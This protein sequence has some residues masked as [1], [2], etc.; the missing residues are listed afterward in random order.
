MNKDQKNTTI[1]LA[2]NTLIYNFLELQ[3]CSDFFVN[4]L[5][6]GELRDEW[7]MIA[8]K[9]WQVAGKTDRYLREQIF[10]FEEIGKEKE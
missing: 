9:I 1:V 10:L 3:R 2:K 6:D 4:I 5:P 7:N 8:T